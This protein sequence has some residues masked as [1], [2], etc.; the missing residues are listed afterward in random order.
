MRNKIFNQLLTIVEIRV[1]ETQDYFVSQLVSVEKRL[2]EI[3]ARTHGGYEIRQCSD[4][5][6]KAINIKSS[7]LIDAVTKLA[8]DCGRNFSE[9]QYAILN[10]KCSKCF[11]SIIG[12]FSNILKEESALTESLQVSIKTQKES[13]LYKIEKNILA[14]RIF[15]NKKVDKALCWTVV[16]VIISTLLSIFAIVVSIIK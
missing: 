5:F 8:I 3:N 13:V 15:L 10:E 16:G 12:R 7:E 2:K 6:F 4:D 1:A 9:K 14:I 11:E